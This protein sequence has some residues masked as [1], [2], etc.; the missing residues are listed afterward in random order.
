MNSSENTTATTDDH[1]EEKDIGVVILF[2]PFSVL[3]SC[4]CKIVLSKI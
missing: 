3:A 1:E 2:L 4:L